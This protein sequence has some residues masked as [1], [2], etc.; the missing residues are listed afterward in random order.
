[1]SI[2]SAKNTL[3]ELGGYRDGFCQPWSLDMALP[4]N[5]KVSSNMYITFCDATGESDPTRVMQLYDSLVRDV[6]GDNF[7]YSESMETRIDNKQGIL[8]LLEKV[9]KEDLLVTLLLADSD[10]SFH[11]ISF[12]KIIE[13]SAKRAV[14]VIMPP[15]F[16][17]TD[18]DSESVETLTT[19][20]IVVTPDQNHDTNSFEFIANYLE[21]SLAPGPNVIF[22]PTNIPK[23]K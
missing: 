18:T 19:G 22:W 4:G 10:G 12:F 8:D 9:E 20:P 1:M 14:G 17:E 2:E 5:L 7:H 13:H 16:T 6:W 3:S 11:A 23:R 21:P 15:V